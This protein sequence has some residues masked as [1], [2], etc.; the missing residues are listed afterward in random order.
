VCHIEEA[1]SG[2]FANAAKV[3]KIC[4]LSLTGTGHPSKPNND[5]IGSQA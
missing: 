1:I 3:E 5:A 4:A 2:D